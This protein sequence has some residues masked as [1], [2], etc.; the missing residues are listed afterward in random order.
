[1]GKRD[2]DVDEEQL[3]QFIQVL[4]K[5]QQ[6]TRDQFEAVSVAWTNFDESYQSTQKEEFKKQFEATQSSIDYTLNTG[7]DALSWLRRFHDIVREFNS[8]G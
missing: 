4:D 3:E 6:L 2:I 5:F 1:M 8:Y 7:E